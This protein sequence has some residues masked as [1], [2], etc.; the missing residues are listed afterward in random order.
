MLM[1]AAKSSD[2]DLIVLCGHEQRARKHVQ[3][4]Q[5]EGA[6]FAHGKHVVLCT[7]AWNACLQ[8]WHKLH[9]VLSFLWCC[10]MAESL[11]HENC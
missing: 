11:K 1:V 2:H 3:C 4:E 8:L 6:N 9:L 7:Q 5:E 10:L